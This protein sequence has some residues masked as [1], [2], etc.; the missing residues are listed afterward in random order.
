[1]SEPTRSDHPAVKAAANPVAIVTGAGSGV[2]RRVAVRLS[3]RGWRVALAGRRADALRE[4]AE[5]CAGEPPLIVPTDLATPGAA[6]DLVARTYS[7]FGR[8]DSIINNAGTAP[9]VPIGETTAEMLREVLAVNT[10]GPG[11]L[12]AAGFPL[13][14]AAGAGR[15][16]NVASVAVKDPFPGFFA[17]AAS[18]CAIDSF[19][20]SIENEGRSHGV[21]GFTVAPGAIETGMLR[22]LFPEDALPATQTLDPD[23]VADLIAKCA[24]GERDEDAGKTIYLSA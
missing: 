22:A 13:M 20:R 12:I 24:L 11:A 3:E 1:M 10:V 6:E 14:V 5:A 9:L 2:G 4:T 19:T 21:R 16:V 8:L 17:Y 7:E 23:E 18:K 15:I